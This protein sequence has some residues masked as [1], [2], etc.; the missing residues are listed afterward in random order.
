MTLPVS[1]RSTETSA[2]RLEAAEAANARGCLGAQPDRAVL[3]I[4]GGVA[5]FA[6]AESPL[7]H[8]V[9]IGL[10]GPVRPAELD[11][12]ERFFRSRGARPAIDLCPFADLGLLP[13][14]AGRGYHL[15][16]FNNVLVRRMTGV[17]V[18]L[19]PRVRRTLADE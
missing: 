17:E 14:L 5:I 10:N 1:P 11:E 2:R 4:A 12:M 18:A 8:A 15:T 13:Q 7:T 16:E 3:E 19:T 6:G 9:A